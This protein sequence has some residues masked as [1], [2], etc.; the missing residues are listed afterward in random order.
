[1]NVPALDIPQSLSDIEVITENLGLVVDTSSQTIS[2]NLPISLSV[3][4]A[5]E[6]ILNTGAEVVSDINYNVADAIPVNTASQVT[7][8]LDQIL[9][10]TISYL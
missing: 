10:E 4:D 8:I 5:S 2:A 6:V 9:Y 3:N 7:L 1:M